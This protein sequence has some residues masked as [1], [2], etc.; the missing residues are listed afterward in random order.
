MKRIW[1]AKDVDMSV[2]A[3]KTVGIIGYGIQG[4]PQALNLRDSGVKVIV[5]G[6]KEGRGVAAARQDGFETYSISEAAKRS[7]VVFLLTPDDTHQA[8]L[9]GEV[10]PALRDGAALG[11]ACGYAVRF[12]GVQLPSNADVIMVA[13]KGPGRTL[14]ER[15]VA[16]SG[17]PALV[18]VRQDVSGRACGVALAYAAAIG[19]GRVAI[20]ES[21]FEEEADTDLFGEQAVL[22]GGIPKLMEAGFEILVSKGY[23]PEAAYIECIWEAKAIVDLIFERGI[24]GMYANVSPTARYGGLTRGPRVIDAS[25]EKKMRGVLDEI[26][27]GAF[28]AELAEAGGATAKV[29]AEL[30]ETWAHLQAA[31]QSRAADRDAA[32]R[33]A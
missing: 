32:K 2:L 28:A 26:R 25:V 30:S 3:G 11:F 18:G 1:H 6:R 9:S 22:C 27:S 21:S 8:L 17:L 31:F 29:P 7:D 20:I 14:R 5:G 33:K 4:R 12:G 24:D 23:S 10:N 16:G 15:F 19:S 13:P